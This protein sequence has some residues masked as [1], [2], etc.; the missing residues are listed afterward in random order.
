[1]QVLCNNL[2]GRRNENNFKGTHGN[3]VDEQIV[4]GWRV[5]AKVLGLLT[6]SLSHCSWSDG[7]GSV[8]QSSPA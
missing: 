8:A 3:M 2:Q 5:M 6:M 1:M 4:R 7:L